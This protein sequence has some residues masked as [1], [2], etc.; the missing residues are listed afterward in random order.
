[1]MTRS[2]LGPDRRLRAQEIPAPAA[3]FQGVFEIIVVEQFFEPFVRGHKESPIAGVGLGLALCRSIV[4]AHGGTIRAEAA[5]PS[6]TRFEIRLP[7]GSP[8]IIEK[9]D[10]M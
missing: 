10:A 1:M 6:G 7:L 8:P 9:E 2:R 4:E 5:Q 3:W